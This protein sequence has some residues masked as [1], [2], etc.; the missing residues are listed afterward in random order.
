MEETKTSLRGY[1]YSNGEKLLVMLKYMLVL[2]LVHCLSGPL[3]VRNK[4]AGSQ[5]Y[6]QLDT[7]ATREVDKWMSERLGVVVRFFL[8]GSHD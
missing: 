1:C 3:L 2:G 4:V 5:L 8:F 6:L 7:V